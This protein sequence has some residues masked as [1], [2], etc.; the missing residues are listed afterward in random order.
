MLTVR[1]SINI[2]GLRTITLVRLGSN[3]AL[4]FIN[5]TIFFLVGC[6]PFLQHKISKML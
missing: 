3:E 2:I 6:V 4:G 5:L 1:V